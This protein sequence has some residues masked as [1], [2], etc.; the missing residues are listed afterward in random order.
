MAEPIVYGAAY[1]TYVRSVRMALAEK[2]VTYRLVEVDLFTG[3][4]QA[5]EH[6]ARQPFGKIPA[7]EHDGFK[8]FETSAIVRYVDEAFA[9]PPL[10]PA[11]PRARARMNQIMAV[12]DS[13]AYGALIGTILIQRAIAP[14]MGGQ[15]DEE[16]IQA[17]VPK[18]RTAME[19]ID[20]LLGDQP[21]LAGDALS[22]ADLYVVPVYDYALQTPEGA[23]ILAKAPALKRWWNG[24]GTRPSVAETRPQLG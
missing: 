20:R 10:Q 9:G 17:A 5:P 24:I 22:L 23:D 15:P 3:Q 13:Y 12:I 21:F 6:L 8:L 7:F 18:G 4:A 14:R 19:V 2:G 1:S 11:D 16:A